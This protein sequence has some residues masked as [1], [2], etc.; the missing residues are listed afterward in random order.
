[1]KSTCPICNTTY[2][3]IPLNTVKDGKQVEV[4]PTC[5]KTLDAEYRKNSCVACVFFHVGACELYGTEL[6]EPYVQNQK[7]DFFTVT[8]DQQKVAMVK[9]KKY[10]LTGHFEKVAQEYDKL[11]MTE[12]AE[13]ARQIVK[14]KPTPILDINELV[15]QLSQR[16]QTLTYFCCYCGVPLKV[17]AKH[18]IQKTCPNCKF[19]LSAIDLVKLINQHL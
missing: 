8:N 3:G 6:D 16:G 15:V 5:Y 11:G 14:A 17:G 2:R 19:D 10:E 18:E 4:C 9:I 7:C 13:E 12:K 1:M